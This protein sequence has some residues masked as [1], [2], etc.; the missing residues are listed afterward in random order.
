MPSWNELSLEEHLAM[1]LRDI[2]AANALLPALHDQ[3]D[4]DLVSAT[5]EHLEAELRRV[6]IRSGQVDVVTF[7]EDPEADSPPGVEFAS[8]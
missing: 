4:V 3:A 1:L 5:I 6:L 7:G 2:D 8:L